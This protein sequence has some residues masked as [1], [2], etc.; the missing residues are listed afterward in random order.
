MDKPTYYTI[1]PAIVRYDGKLSPNS[2]L[3]YGEL[4]ALSDRL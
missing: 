4:G 2:K 1:I 3:L